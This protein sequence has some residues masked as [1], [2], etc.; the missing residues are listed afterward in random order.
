LQVYLL[1]NFYGW[2]WTGQEI[3]VEQEMAIIGR[4]VV[5]QHNVRR[6]YK[7]L[8]VEKYWSGYNKEKD[9]AGCMDLA[10][11]KVFGYE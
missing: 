2:G 3:N 7:W 11:V 1:G 9:W 5:V 4:Y 6:F 8:E 10:E